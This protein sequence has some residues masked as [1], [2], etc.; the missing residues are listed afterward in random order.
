MRYLLLTMRKTAAIS[1]ARAGIIRLC[2]LCYGV[3]AVVG[4]VMFVSGLFSL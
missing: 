2:R 1:P 4:L 3:A